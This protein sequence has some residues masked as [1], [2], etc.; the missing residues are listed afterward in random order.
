MRIDILYTLFL[1]DIFTI[2]YITFAENGI[3]SYLDYSLKYIAFHTGIYNIVD[4]IL[5]CTFCLSL[6]ISMWYLIYTLDNIPDII[7]YLLLNFV[8][9]KILVYL[10]NKITEQ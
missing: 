1:I 8:M 5:S 7:T 10:N 3:T 2:F 9:L 6:Q 4:K